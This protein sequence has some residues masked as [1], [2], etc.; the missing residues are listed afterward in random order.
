MEKWTFLTLPG[1]ELRP[2]RRQAHSQS[3]YRLCYSGSDKIRL[4][5][6][7]IIVATRD[8]AVPFVDAVLPLDF[9][10]S[11]S[12]Y[13][14]SWISLT[15]IMTFHVSRLFFMGTTPA[16]WT[17]LYWPRNRPV[18]VQGRSCLCLPSNGKSRFHYHGTRTMWNSASRFGHL[19]LDIHG[20]GGSQI[21]Y[22]HTCNVKR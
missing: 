6:W 4:T 13:S 10:V 14:R 18:V 16:D 9:R 3:L 8:L 1:F 11:S 22:G 21:P 5:C 17:W 2:Y 15:R 12:D 20:L 7:N 19:S